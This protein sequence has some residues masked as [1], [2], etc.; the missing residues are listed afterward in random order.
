MKTGVFSGISFEEYE[1]IPAINKSG[2][3]EFKKSPLHYWAR[4]LDPAREPRP[5]TP[6]LSL[7]KA[8]H[9]AIL[10]PEIFESQYRLKPEPEDFPEYLASLDDYKKV[11]ASLGIKVSGTKPEL[12][13]RIQEVSEL[14]L[15]SAPRF[16]DDLFARY[17]TYTLLTKKEMKTCQAIAARV[18]GSAA[19]QELFDGGKAEQVLVWQDPAT[20]VY[21]KA[22]LD[23]LSN[24]NYILDPKSTEDAGFNAFQR[25][26]ETY[27]YYRQAA[28]YLTGLL[29]IT[30]KPGLFVFVAFEK[31]APYAVGF[32]F[33]GSEMLRSGEEENRE[34][35]NRWAKCF[36]ADKWPGYPEELVAINRPAWAKKP[37]TAQAEAY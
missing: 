24:A 7:G 12:K 25:S 23:Y 21:C 30:G 31:T 13:A 10:E 35:L 29:A 2:L 20:G 11:C 1:N 33:A 9:H 34:L 28:W 32:Y 36:A 16:F 27:G 5:S 18:R 6:A 19:C 37:E 8:I 26:I 15:S 22:R 14:S 3:D 4:Y 17:A